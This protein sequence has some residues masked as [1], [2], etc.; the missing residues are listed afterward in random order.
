MTGSSGII[1]SPDTSGSGTYD[2]FIDCFWTIQ[3]HDDFV[4]IFAITEIDIQMDFSTCKADYLEV[5]FFYAF[6]KTLFP[7][8]SLE[9]FVATLL[10]ITYQRHTRGPGH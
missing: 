2:N 7:S 4:I 6:T 3:L 5:I 9:I 10:S 8:V 1:G